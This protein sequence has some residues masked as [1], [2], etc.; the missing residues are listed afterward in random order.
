[1]V[2]IKS[3]AKGGRRP[4]PVLEP[5]EDGAAENGN[6]R[7]GE[8]PA[9]GLE[10]ETDHASGETEPAKRFRLPPQQGSPQ[11]HDDQEDRPNELHSPHAPVHVMFYTRS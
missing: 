9:D 6:P 5:S 8:S 3:L 10:R 1:M 4:R 7:H 11:N 2:V